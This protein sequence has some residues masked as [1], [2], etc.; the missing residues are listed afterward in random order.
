MTT[1]QIVNINQLETLLDALQKAFRPIVITPD[2]TER[3]LMYDGG[4][5]CVIK[6]IEAHIDKCKRTS[7]ISV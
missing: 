4:K 7:N 6:W 2:K 3:E 5:Q 1:T